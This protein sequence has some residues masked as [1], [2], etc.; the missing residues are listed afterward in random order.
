KKSPMGVR[1]KAKYHVNSYAANLMTGYRFSTGFAPE[2][3][4]RY[5]HV[6]QE[7]YTDGA[8]RIKSDSNNIWTAVAG[9]DY[10]KAVKTDDVTFTPHAN[11]AALYD[12]KSDGSEANV[13]VIGGGNYQIRGERLHR[14]GVEAGAGVTATMGDWD[15]SLDYR[16]EYR[17]DFQSHTGMVKA[18]YNF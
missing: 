4:L 6:D 1:M 8:Q 9:V 13:H 12:L 7:S 3:G 14:F 10:A 11:V 16:G 15:L 18:K 5:L 2:G 17:R